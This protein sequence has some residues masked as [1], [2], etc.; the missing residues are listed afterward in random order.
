MASRLSIIVPIHNEERFL[1]AVLKDLD[2]LDVGIPIEIVAVDDASSDSTPQILA[3][4]S[5]RTPLV[6]RRHDLNRGK[7]GAVR[8][9]VKA[10]SG[11]LCIV[12]DADPEYSASDVP[13]LVKAFLAHNVDAVYGVR[14]FE[15]HSA[16]SFWYVVGNKAVT[17]FANVLYNSYIRD[18]ETCLKLM[19]RSTLEA[20]SLESNTFTI[21]AEITAK[22][23]RSKAR[24]FE[25]P[26]SYSART[27]QEGKKLAARDGVLAL[28]ALVR[29]RFGPTL[30]GV[31][32]GRG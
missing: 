17:L 32:R 3:E 29:Y 12:F 2:D 30:P 4:A 21:E 31:G 14:S 26:I 20:M 19:P 6:V 25:I 15:G 10:A 5:L 11:D 8:T 28:L 24:I 9:G 23:L 18:L 16:Y 1:A 13:R 27:R 7:G 22:L